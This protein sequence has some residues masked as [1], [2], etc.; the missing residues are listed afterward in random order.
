MEP[1]KAILRSGFLVLAIMALAVPASA[2][3]YEDGFAAHQS[4]D[5]ATALEFWRPLAEQGDAEAQYALGLMHFIGRGIPQDDA[6]AVKWWREAA[7][8]A[9]VEA[10]TNLGSMYAGGRG[11]PQDYVSAH[12]WFYLAAAQGDEKAKQGQDRTARQMTPDQIAEAQRLSSECYASKY[13]NCDAP[14][15]TTATNNPGGPGAMTIR[16]VCSKLVAG[17]K[18]YSSHCTGEVASVTNPDGGSPGSA[19]QKSVLRRFLSQIG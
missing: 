15:R 3:P 4:G 5:Y 6:G 16:G 7:M 19:L 14:V 1:M 2:G 10:Q 8:Q 18:E 11:V 13:R 17:G 12:M 9:H